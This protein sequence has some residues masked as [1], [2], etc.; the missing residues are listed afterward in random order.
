[1]NTNTYN[2]SV[3]S[4]GSAFYF[5]SGANNF[6]LPNMTGQPIGAMV[7]LSANVPANI[8]ATNAVIDNRSNGG[9][10]TIS[11]IH[12]EDVFLVWNGSNSWLTI[13]GSYVIRA[14]SVSTP[15]SMFGASISVNGYQ[16]LP[17]GM[18]I[19]WGKTSGGNG[20]Y[21]YSFPIAFPN[22]CVN[23]LSQT[24]NA[25]ANDDDSTTNGTEPIS[26]SQFNITL[27]KGRAC[28][29]IAIGY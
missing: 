15:A 13:G 17:S 10:S 22:A 9:Q 26:N 21:T 7:Y 6:Y 12:Q 3:S 5:V 4:L 11:L 28:F 14:S 16:K 2:M 29:W 8:I 27:D 20:V 24:A 1:M 18:I 23:I 25:I 19:Q